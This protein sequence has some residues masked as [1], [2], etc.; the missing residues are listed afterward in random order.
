MGQDL[1]G[2]WMP[3]KQAICA[4]KP[5]HEGFCKTAE[6]ME[7]QREYRRS[8]PHRES[9]E[10]RKKS[11]R[12][13]RIS[14]YGLTQ[15]KFGLILAAQKDACASRSRRGSA[16][17]WTMITRAASGRTDHVESASE[18]FYAIPATSRWAT[19]NVG[20]RWL[21]PTWTPLPSR[22]STPPSPA[23]CWFVIGEAVLNAFI[24]NGPS[25]ESR[26]RSESICRS[27]SPGWSDPNAT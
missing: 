2:K 4:R 8:H 19:S 6:A 11:N 21:A 24:L 13:Y 17:M 12:K 10:S 20:M 18:G 5:G 27:G 23:A 1:C 15:E 22:S 9:K 16:S 7:R 26:K 14:S 25:A 3:R